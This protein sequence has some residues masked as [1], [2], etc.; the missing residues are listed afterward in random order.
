MTK[1]KTTAGGPDDAGLKCPACGCRDLRVS[2]KRSA[3]AA[4]KRVRICRHC[5]KRIPTRET[6]TG[7]DQ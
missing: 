4:F 2:Y 1:P 6:I 5:G 7:G 3:R